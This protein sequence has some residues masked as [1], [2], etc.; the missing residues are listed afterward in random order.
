MSK[1]IGPLLKFNK[2]NLARVSKAI[3]KHL[4]PD[5]LPKK[6]H[7]K[8]SDNGMFGHCHTSAGTLYRVFGS[9]KVHMFR[10]LDNDTIWHWWVQDRDGNV[11]DLTASQYA[12]T[13]VRELYK[14]GEKAGMLG[15]LYRERVRILLH[16]VRNE[17]DI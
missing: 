7:Q 12:E 4:T 16:R 3:V 9:Q 2:I 5:L 10:A 6:Y 1:T 17:L 13:I 14:K 8:N 11:I 15:F